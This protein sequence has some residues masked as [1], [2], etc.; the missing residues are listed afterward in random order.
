MGRIIVNKHTTETNDEKIKNL[1]YN[2]GTTV[3]ALGEIV[4]LNKEKN[5][6]IA[7][8]DEFGNLVRVGETKGEGTIGKIQLADKSLKE[9]QE[10]GHTKYQVNVSS[11]HD[12]ALKLISSEEN[13][14]E[15]LYVKPFYGSGI[16][17]NIDVI[18]DNK[19][20]KATTQDTSTLISAM[21]CDLKKASDPVL[22][23]KGNIIEQSKDGLAKALDVKKYVDENKN[24]G[25]K[26]ITTLKT[27]FIDIKEEPDKIIL[28]AHTENLAD[29]KEADAEGNGEIN[30]LA[31]A[32]DVKK[33][34]ENVSPKITVDNET[35]I[36]FEDGKLSNKLLPLK[37][38]HR[39]EAEG[40]PS[41]D[42]LATALDV[43]ENLDAL[44]DR[45]QK[46]LIKKEGGFI[47]IES[48]ETED[49]IYGKVV[50]IKEAN[51]TENGLVTALDAKE[52]LKTCEVNLASVDIVGEDGAVIEE[53][54]NGLATAL[55]VKN[56]FVKREN[57]QINNKKMNGNIDLFGKD[58]KITDK[59]ESYALGNG[60]EINGRDDS[61]KL[62]L[63]KLDTRLKMSDIALAM[64]LNDFNQRF[65]TTKIISLDPNNPIEGFIPGELYNLNGSNGI[66]ESF[67]EN[68][69]LSDS[70]VLPGNIVTYS[71]FFITG[72]N[73]TIDLKN[74]LIFKDVFWEKNQITT[75]EDN[76]AYMIDILFLKEN[77]DRIIKL[78]KI[79]NWRT[80]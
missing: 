67:P 37:F 21:T 33:A 64:S 17:S 9:I 32:L 5:P 41:S 36:S 74:I 51:E 19:F 39:S 46:P 63:E 42:G 47:E 23:E 72:E 56:E 20:I 52:N 10:E 62:A 44:T 78:C 12:N 59:T 6:G 18:G 49:I 71:F 13:G 58:I 55:D 50:K 22:D 45:L 11:K 24:M 28:T 38:A 73:V 7:I 70:S 77:E 57:F 54:K 43:K 69:N 53:G 27:G 48:G 4:I 30:G 34:L 15:G 61:I 3:S 80:I 31:K 26:P 25:G 66:L 40:V 1:F 65:F 35:F 2:K 60:E 16:T 75:L 76:M 29:A 79:N 14:E 8:L 68:I